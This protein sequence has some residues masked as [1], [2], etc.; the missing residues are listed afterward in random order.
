M[1]IIF[2]VYGFCL[3]ANELKTW[4]ITVG[5]KELRII[6]VTKRDEG[7]ASWRKLRNK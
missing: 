1:Y 4:V 7:G 3:K 6:F 5:N 2:I